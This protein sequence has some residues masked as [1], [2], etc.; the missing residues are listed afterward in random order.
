[1]R[2]TL[3]ERFMRNVSPEPMSGCWLWTGALHDSFGYGAVKHG[4]RNSP[5][6]T[7][8][9]V[10][11]R[12]FRGDIPV[13]ML[14]RHHCDNPACVNPHHLDLGTKLDNAQDAVRRG[15]HSHGE[16]HCFAK[17]TDEIAA[18]I[19]FGEISTRE[20]ARRF[21]ISRQ[22]AADIKYGRTWKHVTRANA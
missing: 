17:V 5:T 6:E 18:T 3:E 21:D 13:G 2:K 12:L 22:A 19:R 14:V 11:Y 20:A 1:M 7:A 9:R 10:S 8:H 16:R 4:P 15:R